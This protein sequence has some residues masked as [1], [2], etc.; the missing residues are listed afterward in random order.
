MPCHRV[1]RY[2]DQRCWLDNVVLRA[3]LTQPARN[4]YADFAY[5]RQQ[6]PHGRGV[7]F[8]FS[9][10]VP[11]EGFDDRHVTILFDQRYPSRPIV[12]ADGPDD[13]PHRYAYGTNRS[14]LC[15][16]FP[17]DP[18]E[19]RWTPDDGLL[20]LFAMATVHLMKEAWW[21]ETKVWVGEE[22][23]HAELKEA[24]KAA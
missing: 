3:R 5:R 22:Y 11:L 13:S 10:T 12:L 20:H 23:P 17:S 21:R 8:V 19:R 9:A 4:A 16:W 18:I 1:G 24:E 2:R 7:T 15:L 6:A 14:R